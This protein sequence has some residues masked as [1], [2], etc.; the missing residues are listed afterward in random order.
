MA[1]FDDLP[2]DPERGE[3]ATMTPSAPSSPGPKA[4]LMIVLA[5]ALLAGGVWFYVSRHREPSAAPTAPADATDAAASTV[6]AVADAPPIAATLPPLEEMDPYVRELFTALGSHPELLKWLATDDLVAS[7]A[8]A[9][10]K[11]AQGQSPTRDL[12]VLRPGQSF[13]V[14]RR[15]G[16]TYVAPSSYARYAPLV[17]AVTAVDPVQ[18]AA[19]FTTLRP[20]LAEAYARQGH[21]GGGFDEATRRAVQ[22]VATTP[23]VPEEAALVPGTGGYAYADPALER[24]APAQ[25]QLMRMGPEHVRRVR[26]AARRF[27]EALAAPAAPR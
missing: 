15:G 18:L 16:A 5:T 19:V 3:P 2:L 27:G 17:D 21:P 13:A 12:G 24:L 11:L 10:D 1:S 9:I 4:A 8:T 6:Q 26:D 14:T 22:V 23:D 25:K 20:R 7:I